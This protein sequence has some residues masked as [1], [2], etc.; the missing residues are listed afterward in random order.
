MATG[1]SI[2]CLIIEASDSETIAVFYLIL[3]WLE[4]EFGLGL[5]IDFNAF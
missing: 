3:I 5:E 2:I 4:K 1:E